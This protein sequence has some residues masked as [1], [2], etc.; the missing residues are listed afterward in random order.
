MMGTKKLSEI[1]KE[2]QQAARANEEE[3]KAWVKQQNHKPK[4][5]RPARVLEELVWL[6]ELLRQ[7]VAEKKSADGK[8]KKARRKTAKIR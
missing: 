3:L 1:K 7:A 2:L 8:L 6:R 4:N 5:R